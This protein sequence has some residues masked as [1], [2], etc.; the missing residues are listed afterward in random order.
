MSQ[1]PVTISCH[2]IQ[3]QYPATI[4]SYNILSQY[5]GVEVDDLAGPRPLPSQIEDRREHAERAD[6][7]PAEVADPSTIVPLRAADEAPPP[8]RP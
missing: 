5:P 3:S 8:H 6:E 1:Y 2:N 7:A 4:S